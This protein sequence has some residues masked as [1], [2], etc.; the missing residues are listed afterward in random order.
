[1]TL[2]F[3][4]AEK[5]NAPR[6]GAFFYISTRDLSG[7]RLLGSCIATFAFFARECDGR[8]DTFAHKIHE[9]RYNPFVRIDS[10]TA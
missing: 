4:G 10:R 3:G 8:A 1:M 9:A 5:E 2:A 7:F 6:K